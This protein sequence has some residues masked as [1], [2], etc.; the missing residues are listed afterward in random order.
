MGAGH[1]FELQY[2][3]SSQGIPL[4]RTIPTAFSE[5]QKKVSRSLIGYWAAFMRDLEPGA[6]GGPE[7][8]RY[9]AHGGRRLRFGPDASTVATVPA[10]EH[11]CDFWAT[12]D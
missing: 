3:F 6:G 5:R 10:D 11:Q 9:E 4:V 7:W 8:P 1:G 12:F 2:L